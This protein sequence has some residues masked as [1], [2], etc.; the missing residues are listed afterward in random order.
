M[1]ESRER[2][3]DIDIEA[4]F[5]P[6]AEPALKAY[7]RLLHP[8]DTAELF[9]LVGEAHWLS[10]TRE[11]E[12]E[13]LAEVLAELDEGVRERLGELLRVER[14][15]SA[16]EEL[17]TDDAAD[18]VADLPDDKQEAVLEALDDPEL[19][20]LLAYDDESAGGIMQTELFRVTTG[21]PVE[22]VI[23]ELRRAREEE[24]VE[25]IYTVYVV[26]AAGRL[27]GMV[28]L[29]DLI[30]AT[31]DTAVDQLVHEAEVQVTPEVDQEEVAKLFG[32][33]DVVSVP[34]ID[35]EGVLLGRITFDDIH[36]VLEEEASEDMLKMAGASAEDLV[37][38]GSTLRIAGLRLPWLASSLLG[39]LGAGKLQSLLGGDEP[40]PV[41][42]VILASFVP[43]LMAMSGN[44][45][46]QSAMIVTRGLAIGKI[47]VSMLGRTFG[48]ELVVGVLMGI[49]VGLVVSV[50]SQVDL[51]YNFGL[52]LNYR[53]GLT[54]VL[55]LMMAMMVSAIVGVGVPSLF[56]R[57]GIDPA[58]A[59]GPLVTT[60]CD[61]LAVSIYLGCTFLLR[62]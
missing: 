2:L 7:L 42:I 18:V 52:P 54:L 30:L 12:P 9:S 55:S 10:I 14:L 3:S 29:E 56:K 37:Y 40:D 31:S 51:I 16:V 39:A 6:E 26:D 49:V 38:G 5:K 17:D 62:P 20:R 45:G 53:L 44:V 33:Y 15:V 4:L 41:R 24:E 8:A 57:I 36:D 47:D 50:Y 34:V 32:K 21:T 43:V 23:E 48:R 13:G 11:L 1:N 46:S 28:S 61:L 60:S 19:V 35:V 27:E 58:I 59:S 22:H 25:D